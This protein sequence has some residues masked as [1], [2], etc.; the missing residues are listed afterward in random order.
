MEVAQMDQQF[1]NYKPVQATTKGGNTPSP[2]ILEERKMETF[3]G[4]YFQI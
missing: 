3:V 4:Y 1:A 2:E